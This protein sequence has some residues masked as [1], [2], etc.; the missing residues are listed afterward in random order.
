MP[1]TTEHFNLITDPKLACQC[2]NHWGAAVP[3]FDYDPEFLDKM[4][5]LRI[6]V[7]FGLAVT[8]GTRCKA[9]NYD[10]SHRSFGEHI[11][12][13]G[14]KQTTAMDTACTDNRKRLELN[15]AWILDSR[16]RDYFQ[17]TYFSRTFIHWAKGPA[18]WGLGIGS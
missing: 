18:G 12:I 7:G 3:F 17:G 13:P 8:S 6:L 1:Y 2:V 9:H 15:K 10:I 14:T 5:L 11:A 4:E 16:L